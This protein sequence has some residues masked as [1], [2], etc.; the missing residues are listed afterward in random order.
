[1]ADELQAIKR[2]F[3]LLGGQP[4]KVFPSTGSN[5]DAPVTQGVYVIRYNKIVVHVGR[6]VSGRKG[7]KQRL[8]NHLRGRSSFMK[9][10]YSRDGEVLRHGHTYRYLEVPK[11]RERALLEAY[12][13]GMLCPKHLGLGKKLDS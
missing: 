13:I 2:L 1:M 4:Q 5:I 10:Y 9:I 7:L 6:S 3:V 8:G 11:S 12:A